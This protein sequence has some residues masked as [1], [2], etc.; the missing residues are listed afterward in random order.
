MWAHLILGGCR[1]ISTEGCK[2]ARTQCLSQQKPLLSFKKHKNSCNTRQASTEEEKYFFFFTNISQNFRLTVSRDG[3][4]S[5]SLQRYELLELKRIGGGQLY[6]D[7]S[8][9]NHNGQPS[10]FFNYTCEKSFK[11]DNQTLCFFITV[12]DL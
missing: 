5:Y 7:F 1:H 6:C 9:L 8:D 12:N 11:T 4:E 10:L 2:H 3:S